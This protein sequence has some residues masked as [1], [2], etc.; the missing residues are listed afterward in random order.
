MTD[1]CTSRQAE[2]YGVCEDKNNANKHGEEHPAGPNSRIE[3]VEEICNDGRRNDHRCRELDTADAVSIVAG[4]GREITV[5]DNEVDDGG[6]RSKTRHSSRKNLGA[7][8]WTH[9]YDALKHE[10]TE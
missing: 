7:R 1:C 10:D 2:T 8:S 5:Q 4:G 9:L 6:L 3:S